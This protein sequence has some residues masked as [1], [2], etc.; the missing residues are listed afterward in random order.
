MTNNTFDMFRL[1][2]TVNAEPKD[3]DFSHE[4]TGTVVGKHIVTGLIQVRDQDDDVFDCEPCQLSFN[5]D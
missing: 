1:G 4:F 3:G 5:T 2:D